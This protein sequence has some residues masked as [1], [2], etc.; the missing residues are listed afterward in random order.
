MQDDRLDAAFDAWVQ[1][2]TAALDVVRQATGV[3]EIRRRPGG[4]LPLG[5]PALPADPRLDR[6]EVR[7]AA[8]AA[9]RPPG[10][11]Q[12][13]PGRQPRR[14]LHVLRARRHAHLPAR[15]ATGGVRLPRHDLRHAVR[16]GAGRGAHGNAD[17]DAHR[18]VRDRPQRRGRHSDRA[19]L[20][21][22]RPQAAQLGRARAGHG[23]AG[24]PGDVLREAARPPRPPAG[25]AGARTGRGRAAPHSLVGGAGL[26]ARVRRHVPHLRGRDGD[27]DV[28]RR[29]AT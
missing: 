5:D 13:A 17:A 2:Q 19:G 7:P 6:G 18:R 27:A 10:R 24:H 26:Q 12:E 16:A 14:A 28:A 3:P 1:A 8:P 4:G 15:R 9:L 21:H 22:A 23:A 29:R 20:G 25:G 11:V